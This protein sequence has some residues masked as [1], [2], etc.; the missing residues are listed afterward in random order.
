MFE[1]LGSRC[2]ANGEVINESVKTNGEFLLKSLKERWHANEKSNNDITSY[3]FVFPSSIKGARGIFQSQK[4]VAFQ[5]CAV[6]P[7]IMICHSDVYSTIPHLPVVTTTKI[8]IG[9]L[10]AIE[11]SKR[12]NTVFIEDAE[13]DEE[14]EIYSR[15]FGALKI[16]GNDNG[17]SFIIY[18]FVMTRSFHLTIA[19][20]LAV[21]LSSPGTYLLSVR[22]VSLLDTR[23]MGV[24]V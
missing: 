7:E 4:A 9:F 10:F 12:T 22:L 3:R 15:A 11:S 16:D 2:A 19:Q 8:G 5:D 14:E 6:S 1:Q 24:A 20:N 18:I 13:D 21:Q 23:R 17:E